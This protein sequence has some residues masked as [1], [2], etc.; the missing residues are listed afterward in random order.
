LYDDDDDEENRKE[1]R[2]REGEEKKNETMF[3]S[4]AQTGRDES[5]HIASQLDRI[6]CAFMY[7]VMY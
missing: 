2:E 6:S 7:E 4:S 1:K 3:C 5:E